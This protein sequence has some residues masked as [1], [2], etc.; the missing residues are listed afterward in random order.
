MNVGTF[1]KA[2]TDNMYVGL[3]FVGADQTD[4]II[5]W[6][7]NPVNTG[8][9]DRLRFVFTAHTNLGDGIADQTDG[10]EV[11]RMI[12]VNT[13]SQ[14]NPVIVPRTGIGNFFTGSIIPQYT[15]DVNGQ[16]AIRTV[17]QST[18]ATKVLVLDPNSSNI[19]H[20]MWQDASSLGSGALT[21][22]NGLSIN[23]GA[24]QLGGNPLIQNTLIALNNQNL[25]F[26]TNINPSNTTNNIGIGTTVPAARLH[27]SRSQ[28]TP[29]VLEPIALKIEHSDVASI[30]GTGT[31]IYSTS[32][33]ANRTNRAGFFSS[34]NAAV[35]IGLDATG[36]GIGTYIAGSISRGGRFAGTNSQTNYGVFAG[37]G[38]TSDLSTNHGG[39][40]EIPVT[41]LG[42]IN[43]GVRA[44]V[45]TSS[46]NA[47]NYGGWFEVMP[48]ATGQLHYGVYASVP[49]G[50][51]PNNIV[52]GYFNGDVYSSQLYQGSD[53]M[54][55]TDIQSITNAADILK[56]INVYSYNFVTPSNTSLNLPANHQY[57]V[58][59]QELEQVLPSLVREVIQPGEYDTLGNEILAPLT[60]KAVNYTGLIPFLIAAQ[61]ETDS[62]NAAMAEDI[63]NLTLQLETLQSLVDV[64]CGYD[65]SDFRLNGYEP[66]REIELSDLRTII[67]DQNQP[68]PFKENTVISYFIPEDYKNV[69]LIFFDVSGRVMKEVEIT[70]RGNSSMKVYANDLSSGTYFYSM[71]AD[72]ETVD[73]KKMIYT[74]K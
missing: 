49:A 69:K 70:E 46:V 53:E 14:Q 51:W 34:T 63:K 44:L 22:N 1:M 33:A 3:K 66:D 62:V 42:R 6:G 56:Q 32:T 16:A 45:N 67:L 31:A 10:L 5:D 20:I 61:Q 58:L 29:A 9:E 8:D 57:G 50:A 41:S 71:V 25:Y 38:S 72:G 35:N 36:T 52:A 60:F 23:A 48:T 40:F 26:L 17:N 12:V 74:Q 39:Y 55:K 21:A 30:S 64:C 59:A 73:T 19:G 2:A 37:A 27:I 13:G 47:S 11:A 4:A 54:L 18:T 28:T 68:N 24:V 43:Y 15:L 65:G 7:N